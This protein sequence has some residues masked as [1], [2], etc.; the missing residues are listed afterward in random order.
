MAAD[1]ENVAGLILH[2]TNVASSEQQGLMI[3][4]VIFL[5][6]LNKRQDEI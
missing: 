3:Q 1:V 4:C 2:T 5:N 6:K